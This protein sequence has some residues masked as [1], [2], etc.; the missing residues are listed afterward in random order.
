MSEKKYKLSP[1]MIEQIEEA[2]N[3]EERVEVVPSRDGAR[4]FRVKRS[5]IRTK[6]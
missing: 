3:R 6:P 2:V 4:L 5:E 1:I